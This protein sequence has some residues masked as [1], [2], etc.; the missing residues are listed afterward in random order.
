MHV[1]VAGC[2]FKPTLRIKFVSFTCRPNQRFRRVN[3]HAVGAGLLTDASAMR[4]RPVD[5][6]C[7]PRFVMTIVALRACVG[8][9]VGHLRVR[10]RCLIQIAIAWSRVKRRGPCRL[11]RAGAIYVC[12]GLRACCA[13]GGPRVRVG[14]VYG[15]HSCTAGARC[16]HSCCLAFPHES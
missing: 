15:R 9:L 13:L 11:L 4:Q 8:V 6:P 10:L 2:C 1:A 3:D 7:G 14:C 12:V 5:M 16:I